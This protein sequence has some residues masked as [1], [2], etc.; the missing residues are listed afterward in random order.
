[1]LSNILMVIVLVGVFF[2]DF[3]YRTSA[4]NNDIAK[5]EEKLELDNLN[6][7]MAKCK[8]NIKLELNKNN[9]LSFKCGDITVDSF[10][11]EKTK[12][13]INIAADENGFMIL[14]ASFE[15]RAELLKLAKKKQT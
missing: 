10:I 15:L 13:L 14:P 6:F 7:V 2:I 8:K 1:M 9:Y 5:F 11:A 4:I 3:K 12:K